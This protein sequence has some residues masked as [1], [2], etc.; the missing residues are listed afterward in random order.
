[1]RRVDFEIG[2][3]LKGLEKEGLG[4]KVNVVLTSDHGKVF[5]LPTCPYFPTKL[6]F[7]LKK[8]FPGM[9]SDVGWTDRSIGDYLNASD[10]QLMVGKSYFATIAL[11]NT[12][13][14]SAYF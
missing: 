9:T 1:M 7:F 6:M 11:K 4:D 3:F 8:K 12:S 14:V 10:V 5:F 2:L 13:K